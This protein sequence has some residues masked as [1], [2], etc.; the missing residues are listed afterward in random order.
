MFKVL[1]INIRSE[2]YEHI[3][4]THYERGANYATGKHAHHS[5]TTFCTQTP[6]ALG[7]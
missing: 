1:R 3:W 2:A 6:D 4:S 7:M 5:K